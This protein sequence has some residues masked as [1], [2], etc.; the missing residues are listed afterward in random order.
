MPRPKD[1]AEKP[2]RDWT[3]VPVRMNLERHRE[4]RKLCIDL[5]EPIEVVA[6]RWVEERLAKELDRAK[7]KR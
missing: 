6:G 1:E 5:G 2:E 4:L 3:R 7:P